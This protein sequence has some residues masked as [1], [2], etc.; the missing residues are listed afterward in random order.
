[1]AKSTGPTN[2]VLI[3]LI[4]ELRKTSAKEKVNIWKRVANDLA[5]PSRQRREVNLSSIDKHSKAKESIIVPGKV[6]GVGDLTHNVTVAA[7]QFSEGAKKKVKE[8]LSI[9]ELMKKNPKGK[10]VRIIG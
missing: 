10:D 7:W 3:T 6:L 1:M 9:E 4:R 5:K 2:P 8:A